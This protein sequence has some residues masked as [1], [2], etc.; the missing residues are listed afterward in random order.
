M[1]IS[2]FGMR[3]MRQFTSVY[4][5]EDPIELYESIIV[6]NYVDSIYKTYYDMNID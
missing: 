6:I 2:K 5:W 3:R 1:N 4:N